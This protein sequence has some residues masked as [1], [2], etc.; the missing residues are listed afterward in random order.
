MYMNYNILYF[1]SQYPNKNQILPIIQIGFLMKRSRPNTPM[2][3]DRQPA[4]QSLTIYSTPKN[5]TRHI[6]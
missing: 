6:S 3:L 1:S 2:Y 4:D 5:A